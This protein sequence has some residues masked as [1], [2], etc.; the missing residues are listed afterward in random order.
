MGGELHINDGNV[1]ASYKKNGTG[2]GMH[3]VVTVLS[4]LLI[5]FVCRSTI[6]SSVGSIRCHRVHEDLVSLT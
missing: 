3:V 4:D 5:F 1:A 6:S 2:V